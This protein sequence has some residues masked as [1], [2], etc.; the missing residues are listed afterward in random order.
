MA[1]LVSNWIDS[2]NKENN[3]LVSNPSERYWWP[4]TEW[5][6]VYV[7]ASAFEA[8]HRKQVFGN[9]GNVI[10]FMRDPPCFAF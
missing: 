2:D 10:Y 1:H 5:V 6:F 8:N 4:L 7:V 3:N 9:E